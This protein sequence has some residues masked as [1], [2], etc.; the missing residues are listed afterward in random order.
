MKDRQFLMWLHRRLVCTHHESECV[1]YM[2]KLRAIIRATPA[3]R[4]SPNWITENSLEEL[5]NDLQR[6]DT[7]SC[8]GARF[9][10]T[11]MVLKTVDPA[12]LALEEGKAGVSR[13]LESVQKLLTDFSDFMEDERKKRERIE[14]EIRASVCSE[15]KGEGGAN[16]ETKDN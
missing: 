4:E 1:D 10:A 6:A 12:T 9:C 15:K 5:E 13:T 11:G 14:A 16:E 8:L 3:D 7:L 2:H